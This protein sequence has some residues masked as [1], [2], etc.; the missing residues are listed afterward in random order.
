MAHLGN[1]MTKKESVIEKERLLDSEGR[2][3]TQSLFLELGYTQYSVY[4]LKEYDYAYKGVNYPSLKRLYLQEEDVT[5]Y[6][7]ATKHLL[8]WKHWKRL[9]ENKQI[10]KH[11]DEWR[12]ELELKIRAQAIRDMQTLCASENGNFSAAK[13]LADRGW[14]KRAPGRPTKLDKEKEDRLA[15][16]LSEEFSA[17]VIRMKGL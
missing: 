9:C 5:E 7:F 10:R 8:G 11:V 13:F 6:E 3:L 15:D 12:E 1:Q 17:D 16:R 14:E 2:P 4:T